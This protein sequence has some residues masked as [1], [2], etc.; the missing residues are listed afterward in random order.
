[1]VAVASEIVAAR[2]RTQRNPFV[3]TG[4]CEQETGTE[5]ARGIVFEALC[6]IQQSIRYD[7]LVDHVRFVTIDIRPDA[8]HVQFVHRVEQLD[9]KSVV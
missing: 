7:D 5:N 9:R 8:V 3:G 2:K 4:F 6:G 1:M